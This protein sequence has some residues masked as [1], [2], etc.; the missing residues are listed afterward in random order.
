MKC[1]VKISIEKNEIKMNNKEIQIDFFKNIVIKLTKTGR[2]RTK[3]ISKPKLLQFI[4]HFSIL[5]NISYIF[6]FFLELV[7]DLEQMFIVARAYGYTCSK[8]AIG[9]VILWIL[10]VQA[11]LSYLMMFSS[12]LLQTLTFVVQSLSFFLSFFKINF[13]TTGNCG[14]ED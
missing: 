2:I 14:T 12:K 5:L 3:I 4:N 9:L 13:Q 8:K 11:S 10:G 7:F 6:F 1:C